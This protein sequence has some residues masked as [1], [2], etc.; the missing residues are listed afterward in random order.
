[1]SELAKKS[2][3][4]EL[5]TRLESGA[6]SYEAYDNPDALALDW[7]EDNAGPKAAAFI[8]AQAER[9]E[10][11]EKF[12][13]DV[14]DGIDVLVAPMKRIELNVAQLQADN[15]ALKERIEGLEEHLDAAVDDLQGVLNKVASW[16]NHW[17]SLPAL[18]ADKGEG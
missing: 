18:P 1:M 9:I 12:Q 3:A 10:G 5:A 4:E 17:L 7:W 14:G 15:E 16:P 2:K 13:K 8:R 6:P 11:F